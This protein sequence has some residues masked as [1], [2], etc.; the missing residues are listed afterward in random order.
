MPPLNAPASPFLSLIVPIGPGDE[1]WQ[2]LLKNLKWLRSPLLSSNVELILVAPCPCPSPGDLPGLPGQRPFRKILWV[3]S[4]PSEIGRSQQM[5]TGAHLAKGQHLCFLHADSKFG[6][7]AAIEALFDSLK[8]HPQCLH[9]FRPKF[10]NDGPFLTILNSIGIL[11][12]SEVFNLPFGDQGF[13][14][15][16]ALFMD[17][18]GFDEQ[19]DCQEDHLLVWKAR[20]R[21]HSIR[22]IEATLYTSAR[23]YRRQGWFSTT[24]RHLYLTYRLA[25]PQWLRLLQIKY[26]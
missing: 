5:N 2:E 23:K 17:L 7:R 16:R 11:L 18:K 25:F 8:N 14:L 13:C 19:L 22:P 1:S 3:E 9:F 10:L 6:H 24:I 20:Q 21:G 26:R 12:R 4:S 15:S